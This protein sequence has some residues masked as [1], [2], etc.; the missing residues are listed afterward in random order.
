MDTYSLWREE[1]ITV[2]EARGVTH[3]AGVPGVICRNPQAPE[4]E[5]LYRKTFINGLKRIYFPDEM[6]SALSTYLRGRNTFV[7]A[8]NGYSAISPENC[9]AWGVKPGAYE[10]ACEVFL[11]EMCK[12]FRATFPDADVRF[13]H[14][15]SDMGVDRAISKA[16]TALR[17]PQLG[18]SCPD[19]LFFVPD[20]EHPVYVAESV[21]AYSHAFVRNS[22]IL[23]AANG[24]LQAYRMDIAAVF[25][26]DKFLLSVNIL[27][28][29][30]SNGGPPARNA[31]GKIED[32]VA[33]F[34]Q[35]VFTIG[36]QFIGSSRRDAWG[37]ALG[38][39]RHVLTRIG[40]QVLPPDIGLEINV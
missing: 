21:E 12:H 17:R 28:L 33:H 5:R 9:A 10:K 7:I 6:E 23:I 31:A 39:C 36:Q 30:S 40:R 8:M 1:L 11:I 32:A 14:G 35:R 3:L 25:E 38:E 16:A 24:R 37:E 34:E 22:D 26:Y 13:T 29:I 20:D 27:Q 4:P 15:A 2:V 19:Y 18:F